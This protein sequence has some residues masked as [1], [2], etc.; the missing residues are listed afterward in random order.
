MSPG[1]AKGIGLAV[2]RRIV[3]LDTAIVPPPKQLAAVIEQRRAD[4][5]A[6]FGKPLPSFFDGDTQH[7][8][9]WIGGGRRVVRC[10]HRK[11]PPKVYLWRGEFLEESSG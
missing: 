7:A 11:W 9:V 6:A 5:D 1:L 10:S 2:D 8:G 3:F 4:G